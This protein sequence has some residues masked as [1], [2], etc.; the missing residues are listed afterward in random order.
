M[1]IS[2]L[3]VLFV[4]HAYVVGVNQGKL[5]AIAKTGKVKVGLLA[6]SNWKAIEWNRLLELEQ[7][8][9]DIQIYSAPVL[10]S[11]RGGAHFYLP[12]TLWQ[13]L[14]D[15]KPDI[16]QVEEEVFSCCA[17]E[18]A[19]WSRLTGKSL[20]VF[21]WENMDRIFSPPRLWIRNFVLNTASLIIA[22]N[23]EGANLLR[24]WGYK[25]KVEIMPQMGVDT[26]LFTPLSSNSKNNDLQIGYL[27]RLVPEKGIDILFSAVHQLRDRGLNCR[28]ILCGSG[29]SET[30]LRQEAKKLHIE[31]L[32][33]WRGAVRHQEAPIEISKLDVLV[34]P[35]RTIATWKE[36]FGHV[37][38]EAMAMGVPVI[39]SSCGEI[40]N[41]IAR[42][43]LVFEEEDATGLATILERMI[44]DRDWKE[45]IKQYGIKRVQQFYSH[46]QIAEKSI[47]LWKMLKNQI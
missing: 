4:S 18:L 10:F 31:N 5:D 36:Q 41:A 33:I 21:G 17:L 26:D 27:G 30:D 12:W 11:G 19:I 40:P 32:I 42:S 2:P 43:D 24:H 13:V 46:Q 15:F 34:L 1:F 9:P 20:V 44:K 25:G 3:R 35:S 6:P 16:V 22:G 37:L 8:Y 29:K 14:Q 28:V 45:E 39:G 47:D 23:H 7:P 38:I